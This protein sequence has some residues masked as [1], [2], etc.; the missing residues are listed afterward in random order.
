MRR[1]ELRFALVVAVAVAL[2][3]ALAPLARPAAAQWEAP[4]DAADKANP[5]PHNDA[6]LAAGKAIYE[7]NCAVCHDDRGRGK[8]PAAIALTPR[9]RPL[10]DAGVVSQSDG[11]LFWKITSGRA[12][13]PAWNQLSDKQRWEVVHYLH[14]L[15]GVKRGG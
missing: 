15:M 2:A 9:P 1:T 12:P 7:V 11:A 5:L 13:M 14:K 10:N 8:G 6:V 4:R 3:A